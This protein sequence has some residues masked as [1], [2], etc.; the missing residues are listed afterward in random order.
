MEYGYVDATDECGPIAKLIKRGMAESTGIMQQGCF[1]LDKERN[2][3][4]G[5]S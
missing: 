3:C 4:R 1:L 2:R 5:I